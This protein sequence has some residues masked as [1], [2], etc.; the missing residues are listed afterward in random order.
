[1]PNFDLFDLLA[2]IYDRFIKPTDL[3]RFCTIVGLPI[4]GRLLD[5]GGGTGQK[6]HRLLR[7]VDEIVIVDASWGMLSQANKKSALQV[8]CSQTEQLPFEEGYF[9]RVIMVDALHHVCDQRSTID[10]L[11]RVV[12]P[13]GRIVIEEPDI[14]AVAVKAIAII[15]KLVLMRSHFLN[16]LKIAALFTYPSAVVKVRL[17][18]S[19]SWIVV[20]KQI[21]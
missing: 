14:R 20:D 9:D 16:P 7:L 15:E 12:K 10:E 18:N 17:E 19:I 5:A 21:S 13:G 11:W 1:M 2:P 3:D 6:S 8:V 4:T